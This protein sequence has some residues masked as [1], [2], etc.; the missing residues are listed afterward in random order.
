[1]IFVIF[2]QLVDNLCKLPKVHFAKITQSWY[3]KKNKSMNHNGAS[4]SSV[5]TGF[6]SP[7][8]GINSAAKSFTSVL[9]RIW[10]TNFNERLG[11][12]EIE[13]SLGYY[14]W[15]NDSEVNFKILLWCHKRSKSLYVSYSPV[16][17][18]SSN[19]RA[20]RKNIFNS[21]TCRWGNNS[22]YVTLR[23]RRSTSGF[24][25]VESSLVSV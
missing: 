14:L 4:S 6:L 25:R 7:I 13:Q 18:E 17:L 1:M 12:H 10:Q 24:Y 2:Y 21:F 15:S 23:H 5:K 20:W 16:E 11:N 8:P 22:Y 19:N 3:E 9:Q